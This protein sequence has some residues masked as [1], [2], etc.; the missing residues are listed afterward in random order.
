MALALKNHDSDSR[1]SRVYS[2]PHVF[3]Y[4]KRYHLRKTIRTINIILQYRYASLQ[5][6]EGAEN[7]AAVQIPYH[8]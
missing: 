8:S 7:S 4:S 1:S 6:S 3:M 2:T 5:S